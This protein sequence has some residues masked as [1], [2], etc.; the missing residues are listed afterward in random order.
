MECELFAAM[1]IND[2]SGGLILSTVP[3]HMRFEVFS[4]VYN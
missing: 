4:G 3:V 2:W 1:Y